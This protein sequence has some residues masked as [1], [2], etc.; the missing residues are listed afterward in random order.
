MTLMAK[1]PGNLLSK[2]KKIP[3]KYCYIFDFSVGKIYR[4]TIPSKIVN[5][6][7]LEEYLEDEYGFKLSNIE[8]MTTA[9]AE[10]IK[11][12]DARVYINKPK[13]LKK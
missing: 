10:T 2:N 11:I 13:S 5:N 1:E 12:L 9:K 4:I 8:Y 3:F 6:F 7:Q